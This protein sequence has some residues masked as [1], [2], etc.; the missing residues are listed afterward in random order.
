ME[1]ECSRSHVLH[2]LAKELYKVCTYFRREAD[3]ICTFLSLRHP[4]SFVPV[5]LVAGILN[6]AMNMTVT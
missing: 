5:T 3:T 1:V 6:T 4:P 2:R